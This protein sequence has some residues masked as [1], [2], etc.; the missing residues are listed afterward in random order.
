MGALGHAYTPVQSLR[1]AIRDQN[2]YKGHIPMN[3]VRINIR[4]YLTFFIEVL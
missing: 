2:H 1:S 4:K 3:S